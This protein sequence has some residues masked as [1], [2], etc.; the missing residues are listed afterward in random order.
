MTNVQSTF[1]RIREG[2]TV[3]AVVPNPTFTAMGTI[4]NVSVIED[5]MIYKE[6]E[7]FTLRLESGSEKPELFIM[8][9]KYGDVTEIEVL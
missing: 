7:A 1:G 3:K 6:S 8:G 5:E 4:D 9:E 2:D